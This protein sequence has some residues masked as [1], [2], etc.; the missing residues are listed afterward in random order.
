M[1]LFV[2][3]MALLVLVG[4]VT[5]GQATTEPEDTE[6]TEPPVRYEGSGTES[7]RS[8]E[9]ETSRT[10]E[11]PPDCERR[12]VE[13][14]GRCLDETTLVY[15]DVEE[16]RAKGVD[17]AAENKRCEVDRRGMPSCQEP[18]S[19]EGTGTGADCGSVSEAGECRDGTVVWCED[20]QLREERCDHGRTCQVDECRNGAGCCSAGSGTVDPDPDPE[21][22]CNEE[23]QWTCNDDRCIW[24][25]LRCN[26]EADCDGGEDEDGC[27][28]DP[29][30]TPGV[31]EASR[32]SCGSNQWACEDG[33]C[34][35]SSWLC[36]G[37]SD[38]DGAEDEA[39][40]G[41][42]A[43][44]CLPGNFDCGNGSCVPESW[45][46]DGTSDC[47]NCADERDCD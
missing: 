22:T 23:T 20:G 29:T 43:S 1:R 37:M 31:C 24:A 2:T 18:T 46:C 21:P 25:D 10:G 8:G 5:S 45:Q 4:C 30:P 28:T 39:G 32:F 17:C 11:L 34:I 42:S 3:P 6:E 27:P 12:N 38:C 13:P 41:S 19:R 14:T 44:D 7:R 16:E 36:D 33:Q 9:S 40:C 47:D 26:G 15:C 35:P